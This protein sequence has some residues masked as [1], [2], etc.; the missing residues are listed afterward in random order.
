[1]TVAP[2]AE[3]AFDTGIATDLEILAYGGLV[4]TYAFHWRKPRRNDHYV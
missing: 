3:I 1:M 4:A 2:V